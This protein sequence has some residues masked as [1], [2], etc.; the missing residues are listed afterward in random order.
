MFLERLIKVG[1]VFAEDLWFPWQ[2]TQ[3]EV[4]LQRLFCDGLP[5]F[6]QALSNKQLLA[7]WPNLTVEAMNNKLFVGFIKIFFINDGFFWFVRWV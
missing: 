7:L 4:S 1:Q 2:L 6:S 3:F 5:Q